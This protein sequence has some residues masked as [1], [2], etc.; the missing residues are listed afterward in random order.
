MA[1]PGQPMFTRRLGPA[2]LLASWSALSIALIVMD[3]R[4]NTLNWL[5]SGAS[6]LFYPLQIAARTPFELGAEINNFLVQHRELQR[7]NAALLSTQLR[8]GAQLSR[9]HS[10]QAENDE[11][12]RQLGLRQAAAYRAASAEILSMPRD[13]FSRRVMLDRGAD[14]GI[15]PGSPVVDGLGLVGQVTKVFPLSSEVTLITDRNQAVPAQIQRT[16]QRVLAYGGSAGMEVRYLPTHT[17]IQP[18][19]V[20]V[21]SGIDRVYP[22]GLAVAKV[23]KVVRLADNPYARISCLPVAG[24]EKSRVLVV[25]NPSGTSP[26]KQSVGV[27]Q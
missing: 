20:L 24:V 22:A 1:T 5:R 7:E 4:F 19:D 3:A 21:T 23:T 18:G 6:T 26:L 17:D 2:V 15:S 12:R 27:P 16:S 9:I 14:A 13:P 8:Y 11:L 25:L 10:L